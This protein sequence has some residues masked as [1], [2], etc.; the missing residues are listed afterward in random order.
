MLALDHEREDFTQRGTASFFGDP[1]QDQSMDNTGWVAEFL[2]QPLER[3]DVSASVRHDD[4]SDFEN[5]TTYRLTASYLL[6][7]DTTRLHTSWGTGR[8]SPTFI[9]RFGYFSGQ[10]LGNP[11]LKPEQTRGFDVGIAQALLTGLLT[12]DLTYFDERLKDEID[13]FLFDSAS[14]LFT[15][16]NLDGES[17]RQ[18]AELE[19]DARLGEA[20]R[21]RLSYTYLDTRQPDPTGGSS[22]EIRRPRHSAALNLNQAVLRGRGNLNLNLTYTGDQ[23]DQYFPP[24]SFSTRTLTLDDYLLLDLTASYALSER[25][26]LYA[27]VNNLLNESYTDVIGYQAPGRGV[28]AGVRFGGAR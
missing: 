12:V 26:T 18:G 24:P 15:A 27:R 13:G 19:L 25:L 8:K 5:T 4:N 17:R 2:S 6:A 7:N 22:R 20:L 3:L 16:A 9:E 21:A 1:N 11:D 10:F 28:Y 23:T 14:G